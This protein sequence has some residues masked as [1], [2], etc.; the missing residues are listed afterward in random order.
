MHHVK[1]LHHFVISGTNELHFDCAAFPPPQTME[2]IHPMMLM[3]P[4][5]CRKEEKRHRLVQAKNAVCKYCKLI[6]NR[7]GCGQVRTTYYKCEA[8]DVN[9]C[10]E[11]TR[12]CF[13]KYH[14]LLAH[15]MPS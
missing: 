4:L 3:P 10:R 5:P 6:G 7:F 11:E 2:Y 14:A 9:L 13:A 12:D 15:G 1:G 8:C